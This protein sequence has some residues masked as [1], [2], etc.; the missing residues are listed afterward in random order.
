[1]LNFSQR[2]ELS[3]HGEVAAGVA[4]ALETRRIAGLVVGAFARDLHLHYGAGLRVDRGTED[5]DFALL[6]QDWQAFATFRQD[7]IDGGSFAP[8]AARQHRLRHGN[9]I[10]VDLVPFGAIETNERQIEWPPMGDFVMDVFG[11]QEALA[12]ADT[13]V[14]PGEVTMRIVSLPALGLLKMVAW[15]DRH[16]R[17]PGKD[18]ADLSSIM[19]NYLAIAANEQRLWSDF[20][21]WVESPDFDYEQSGARMLGHD[22]RGLLNEAGFAKVAG[23]LQPQVDDDDIGELPQEMNRHLPERAHAL[24]KSLYR[25]L[26]QQE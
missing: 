24:L 25:G 8:V 9:G 22:I 5:I 13:V 2:P 16:R 11:F 20:N 26:Q 12:T 19:R 14:L 3:L 6:V 18:A 1:M 7:L 15:Q 23:I 21:A 4:H 10:K 17:S